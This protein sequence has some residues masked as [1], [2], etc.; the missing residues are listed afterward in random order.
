MNVKSAI[1]SY[2]AVVSPYKLSVK[3]PFPGEYK[4]TMSYGNKP[5]AELEYFLDEDDGEV[6]LASGRTY[7]NFQRRGLGTKL[8]AIVLVAAYGAG[9]K[10]A[11]QTSTNVNKMRPGQRPISAY[12]MNKL[13]FRI[14][15]VHGNLSENRTLN[16]NNNSIRKIKN[17]I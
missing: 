14:E 11:V 7:T 17:L 5:A 3:R 13:G 1:L 4:V 2:N 16:M 10:K 8:R 9:F 6:W 12:I 15:R